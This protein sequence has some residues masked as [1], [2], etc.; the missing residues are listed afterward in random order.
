[1]AKERYSKLKVDKYHK[2][3]T[4]LG[5]ILYGPASIESRVKSRNKN[6][7][8]ELGSNMWPGGV[9]YASIQHLLDFFGMDSSFYSAQRLNSDIK[10]KS[11]I[12]R[13]R[14]LLA[15]V[16]GLLTDKINVYNSRE[17]FNRLRELSD[18]SQAYLDSK[19]NNNYLGT[20]P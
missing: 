12:E 16:E 8:A 7:I 2:R 5:I 3:D 6:M 4:Y 9:Q 10:L 14:A 1:M 11:I 19:T 13:S 18:E 17:K 20:P 15:E